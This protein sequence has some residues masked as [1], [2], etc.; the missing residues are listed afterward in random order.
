MQPATC[1]TLDVTYPDSKVH[2]ANMGPIWGRQDPGGPH[3]GHMNFPI[4]V[5]AM[6]CDN[7]TF[8]QYSDVGVWR[9]HFNPLLS[10]WGVITPL[11]SV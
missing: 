9:R 8:L 2:G 4:W 1:P 5:S 6:E 10:K 11:S 7:A 3:V